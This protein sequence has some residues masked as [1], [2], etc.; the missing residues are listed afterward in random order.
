MPLGRKKPTAGEYIL[1]FL[2]G[3]LPGYMQGKQYKDRQD[4][5][6]EQNAKRFDDRKKTQINILTKE[7]D[8][9]SHAAW[10]G[11]LGEG[12]AVSRPTPPEKTEGKQEK[13]TSLKD[14]ESTYKAFNTAEEKKRLEAKRDTEKAKA[15]I[16][17][18][19]KPNFAIYNNQVSRMK[20]IADIQKKK[21][22]E[23][24]KNEEVF[25]YVS[26]VLDK[27]YE[28]V[29]KMVDDR[30]QMFGKSKEEHKQDIMAELEQ[31]PKV[32][33]IMRTF[34]KYDKATKFG[35]KLL[36]SG[37]PASSEE[38]NA[39]IKEDEAEAQPQGKEGGQLMIDANGNR[40][41]VYPDGSF[42]EVK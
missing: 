20:G 12:I 7:Y 13:D 6:D 18:E 27:N 41:M 42:E 19:D 24:M 10:Q 28:T 37:Q 38:F 11:L 36:T 39:I 29:D 31:N 9:G 2:G 17:K 21:I 25:G 3:A 14:F 1:S 34:E 32:R 33:E 23:L 16:D 30:D 8:K 4:K 15:K 22:D 40:A 26:A 5:L 35:E